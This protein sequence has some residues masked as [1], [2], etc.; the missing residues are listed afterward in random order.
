MKCLTRGFMPLAPKAKGDLI[1]WVQLLM[2][3]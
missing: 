2:M 1:A 3:G